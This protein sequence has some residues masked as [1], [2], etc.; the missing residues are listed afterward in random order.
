MK[1]PIVSSSAR[2]AEKQGNSRAHTRQGKFHEMFIQ[3]ELYAESPRSA[4]EL[5]VCAVISWNCS[6]EIVGTVS[7][8]RISSLLAFVPGS[9]E[10]AICK[11]RHGFLRDDRF[12][13]WEPDVDF[14]SSMFGG[15][16]D[17]IC[18]D[19]RLKDR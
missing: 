12:Y 7:V 16:Y 15:P 19:F 13:R 11:P 8:D 10:V 2:T 17:S 1:F 9:G 18:S 6:E 4:V 14:A 5:S 3:P